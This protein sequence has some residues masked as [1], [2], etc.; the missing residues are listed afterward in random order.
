M[1]LQLAVEINFLLHNKWSSNLICSPPSLQGEDARTHGKYV[2]GRLTVS[3][4]AEI[5]CKCVHVCV[6]YACLH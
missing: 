4:R 6:Q 1:Y 2:C 5:K 3:V